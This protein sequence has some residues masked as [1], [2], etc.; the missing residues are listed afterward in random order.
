MGCGC[1]SRPKFFHF[2]E[3]FSKCFLGFGYMFDHTCHPEKGL[4][5]VFTRLGTLT[6]LGGGSEVFRPEWLYK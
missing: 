2:W 3:V 6:H 4:S 1:G 5:W